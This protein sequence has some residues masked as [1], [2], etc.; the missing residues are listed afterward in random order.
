ACLARRSR[1][2]R[3]LA[4]LFV[5]WSLASLIGFAVPN[6]VG[7]NLER[8]ASV[9]LP[10][11]L[12][13]AALARFRPRWL[14][15][16]ALS[17][18]LAYNTVPYALAVSQRSG[19]RSAEASFWAPAL[20]FLRAHSPPSY[21]VEAVPTTQHWEAYYLPRNGFAISR[22]WYRQLD[23]ARNPLLYRRTIPADAYR[24]WLR[25]LGV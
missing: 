20:A 17:A 24:S 1:E 14:A 11:V 16:A 7:A 8:L 3:V 4:A 22:G 2:G 23:L 21:R 19:D 13:L 18:A 25:S 6:P 9:V 5:L 15:V 10:L 12:L